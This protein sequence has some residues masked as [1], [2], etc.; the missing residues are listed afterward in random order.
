[1]PLDG[2]KSGAINFSYSPRTS[3]FL[4]R[5]S[6]FMNNTPIRFACNGCGVCCKGRLIPLTLSE[7][8]QWLLRGHD[9]AVLLEA[10]DESTWTA[11]P[12]QYA[13]SAKR[14]VEKW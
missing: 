12:G 8:R 1:M 3:V 5:V 2:A 11:Q 10:F 6:R 7:T 14:A 4:T 13:H 9:V